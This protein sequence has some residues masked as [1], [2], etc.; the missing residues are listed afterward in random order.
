MKSTHVMFR[1]RLAILAT[2]GIVITL[3]MAG[4]FSAELAEPHRFSEEPPK[5]VNGYL[6]A[7]EEGYGY[8]VAMLQG[9]SESEEAAYVVLISNVSLL[10]WN[11]DFIV[12]ET[13]SASDTSTEWYVIVVS[14][15]QI[16][17]CVER[18]KELSEK[19]NPIEACSSLKE[20]SELK[21]KLGVPG[22]LT[23]RNSTEVYEQLNQR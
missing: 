10:G 17:H 5:I 7:K 4:C 20:F 2:S 3:V 18:L 15:G 1:L 12:A 14:T 9:P 23:M 8:G 6:L 11:N 19:A 16:Y 21:T 13:P 22:D